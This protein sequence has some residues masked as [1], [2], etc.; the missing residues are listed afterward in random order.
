MFEAFNENVIGPV[1]ASEK[2]AG[3]SR[4]PRIMPGNIGPKANVMPMTRGLYT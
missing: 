3:K 1:M 4:V 2:T